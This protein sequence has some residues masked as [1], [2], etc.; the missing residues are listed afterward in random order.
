MCRVR[1]LL[2]G[3]MATV[4][5]RSW[6]R[7]SASISA[8]RSTPN[9][10]WPGAFAARRNLNFD[11]WVGILGFP[12]ITQ[13]ADRHYNEVEIRADGVDHPVV[14]QGLPGG[15]PA[16]DRS[17]RSDS[18][19]ID[20]GRQAAGRRSSRAASSSTPRIVGRFMGIPDLLVEAPP[21]ETNDA[22]G[23]TTESGIS[24]Q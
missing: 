17:D 18:W 16:L 21:K 1:K 3:L 8:R 5:T 23:G 4:T 10:A 6:S 9:I 24:E 11:P 12:F 20:A 22:T 13:A 15:H 19:L 2:I 14:G 7:P